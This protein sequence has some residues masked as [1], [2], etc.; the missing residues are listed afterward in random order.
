MSKNSLTTLDV[1]CYSEFF[2]LLLRKIDELVMI[3]IL[4][5]VTKEII[6]F[7]NTFC[8]KKVG[9]SYRVFITYFLFFTQIDLLPS[10]KNYSFLMN[11]I[12]AT[13]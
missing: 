13:W 2:F 1:F 3:A 5:V 11:M 9:N 8:I 6:S 10:Y 7:C 12:I 4:V